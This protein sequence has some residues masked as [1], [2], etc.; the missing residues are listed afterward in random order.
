LNE[1]GDAKNVRRRTEPNRFIDRHLVA[2]NAFLLKG[3]PPIKY[4]NQ[5]PQPTGVSQVQGDWVY[6]EFQGNTAAK[7][8]D[9]DL[10]ERLKDLFGGK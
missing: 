1:C 3:A 10:L 5:I 2:L 6:D 9:L 7:P 8:I 4:P